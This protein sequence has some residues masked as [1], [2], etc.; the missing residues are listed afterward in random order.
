[1]ETMINGAR[2]HYERE[3]EGLPVLCLH[4]GVADSRMWEPQVWPFARH[5]DVIRPDMRGFGNSELPP[6]G[7]S[8]TADV[9]GLM[10]ELR[11]KPAHLIG[12][13]I[14]GGVVLDFALQHPGRISK[15]VLV[16]PGI[17]G[18]NFGQKYPELFAEVEAAE[19]AGDMDAVNRAEMHLWLD[20]PSRPK[21]YVRQPVRDLFLDRTAAISRATS[22]ARRLSASIRPRRSG[23]KRSAR[24]CS[25]SSATTTSRPS[26]T[27]SSC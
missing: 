25:S 23:C 13:S 26:S 9:L 27:R 19:K 21:G 12:C 10:D 24:R 15:L 17:G 11:L 16:G 2:I 18:T 5:F 14:G 4:A 1:M 6:L 7:W 3:G 20:G 22:R 8:P